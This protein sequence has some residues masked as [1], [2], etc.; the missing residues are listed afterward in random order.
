MGKLN[1]AH[2]KSYHPYRRDNIERVRRD[3]E[4][5]RQAEAVAEGRMM[6]ADSE[7]R[8]D[9]LRARAGLAGGK[10]KKKKRDE[11]EFEA[12][13]AALAGPSTENETAVTTLTSARGHI[14]LFEDLERSVVPVPAQDRGTKKPPPV[15]DDKGVPL[16]PTSADLR[17]WYVDAGRDTAASTSTAR[18]KPWETEEDRRRRDLQRKSAHDPLTAINTQ[19]AS[20]PGAGPSTSSSSSAQRRQGPPS[21]SRPGPQA[22]PE[23]SARLVRESS[24][25]ERARAL[26]AR[27]K[28]EMGSETP[29]TVYGGRSGGYGDVFNRREVEEVRRDRQDRQRGW[30]RERDRDREGGRRYGGR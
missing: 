19:L 17:P 2:H 25:R 21:S 14:N 16:A 26:I 6:L 20:R 29:S 22:P 24:E 11:D 3:E 15:E 1:I 9:L 30:E 4:G 8:I 28:R 5:A 23:V 27:K 7:A 13:A 10:G 18:M 12:A